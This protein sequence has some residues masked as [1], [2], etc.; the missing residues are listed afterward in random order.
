MKATKTTTKSKKTS[1][2]PT[3]KVKSL[4]NMQSDTDVN[5]SYTGTPVN[6]RE[7]PIQDADDL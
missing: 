6:P 1:Y 4:T 7:N 5:G 3:E 2:A